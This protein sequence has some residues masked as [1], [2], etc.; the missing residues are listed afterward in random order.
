LPGVTLG[1]AFAECFLGFA[2]CPRHSAKVLNPVVSHACARLY[3]CTGWGWEEQ[4]KTD[5]RQ[6]N[7]SALL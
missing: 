3:V 7:M 4:E 5:I 2:E 6:E 1:K